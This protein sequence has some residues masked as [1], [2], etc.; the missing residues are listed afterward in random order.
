[1][2][3]F[4]KWQ[5]IETAPES[6]QVFVLT[7]DGLEMQVA[8]RSYDNFWAVPG[9]PSFLPTHWMPLPEPPHV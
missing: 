2:S 1:M 7:W 3:E 4:G 6:D 8:S 5:P 9:L